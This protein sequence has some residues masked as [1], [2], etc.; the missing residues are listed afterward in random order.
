MKQEV[1]KKKK[2]KIDNTIIIF[3]LIFKGLSLTRV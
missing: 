2:N 1:M 3:L